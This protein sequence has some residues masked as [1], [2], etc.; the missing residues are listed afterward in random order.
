MSG[1]IFSKLGLEDDPDLNRR[2]LGVLLF[3]N[4]AGGVAT[5]N[6]EVA[7]ALIEELWAGN[8]DAAKDHSGYWPGLHTFDYVRSAFPDLTAAIK[9]QVV[10]GDAVVTHVELTGTHTAPFLGAEPTGRE[11][12][13]SVVYLDRFPKMARWSS[14]PPTAGWTCCWPSAPFRLPSRGVTPPDAAISHG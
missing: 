5:S 3:L 10:E 2:V 8:L 7:R 11:G 13:W 9:K 1:T 14:T 12:T 4:G 6:A